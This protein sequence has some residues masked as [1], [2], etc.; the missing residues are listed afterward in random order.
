M[1]KIIYVVA[2][3]GFVF[4]PSVWAMSTL[5]DDELADVDG[6][7]LFNLSYLAPADAGNFESANNVGFY[8]LGFEAE[9]A[10]N[11]NIKKLQLGC[12]GINGAGNCDIDIDNFSL[13]GAGNSATS[14]TSS[15]A[16]R[17]ARVQSDAILTNPFFQFAIKNPNT[18]ATREVVGFRT[19]LTTSGLA[20]VLYKTGDVLPNV[21]MNGSIQNAKANVTINQSLGYIHSLP[22]NSPFY[23]SVQ[24]QDMRWPGT[25][26]GP[27]PENPAS[28]VTDIAQKGWWM[29]FADPINL[30]SVDPTQSIDIEP[31][32]PQIASAVSTW[33]AS[34]PATSSD[35]AGLLG[36]GTL[37]V[38]AG[39]VNLAAFPLSLIL[40]DLQLN[41][42]N[43][44]PNCYGGLR[45]C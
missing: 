14:N 15:T 30:G 40:T 16:D 31:L 32:F 4:A 37:D 36:I 18:A 26:S 25:Y 19:V 6:Q 11:L 1:K 39:N 21:Y 34:N 23:L 12:G 10:A 44:A 29:S 24:Q 35:L 20:S 41:G 3:S 17:A 45:F 43:F 7:A 13:S 9:I 5:S 22:I 28:T 38:N 27:D 8:K 42:Q 2:L 33:L